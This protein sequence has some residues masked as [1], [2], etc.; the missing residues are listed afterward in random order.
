[1][2]RLMLIGVM[3]LAMPSALVAGPRKSTALPISPSRTEADTQI[4]RDWDEAMRIRA[5][6]YEWPAVRDSQL[7]LYRPA[8]PKSETPSAP[9]N[10][11]FAPG[12]YRR[13]WAAQLPSK[14]AAPPA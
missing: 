8:R 3:L 7:E 1:M 14:T 12:F 2:K 4:L 11:R 13:F 6:Q 5:L 10:K 9:R